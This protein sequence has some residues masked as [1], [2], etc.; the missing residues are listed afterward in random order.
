MKGVYCILCCNNQKCEFLKPGC[1]G[2]FKNK[3]PNVSL[4][5]LQANWIENTDVVYIG[6]AG[7]AG[8]IT[9]LTSTYEY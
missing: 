9:T 5:E 8:K 7:G 1:G 2:H 3:D 4:S 6:K